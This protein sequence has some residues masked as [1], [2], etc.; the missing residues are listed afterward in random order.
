MFLLQM[1]GYPGGGK[2]T[3]SKMIAKHLN[4]IVIDRDIIKTSMINSKVPNDI[5]ADASYSVVFDLAEFYLDMNISVIIDTPCYYEESLNNG[6][7][8]AKMYGAAYKYIECKV[9]DYSIIKERIS[10]RNGL[11]SQIKNT[12]EENFNNSKDKSKKLSDG[13]YLVIDTTLDMNYNM[14]IIRRYLEV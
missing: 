11:V 6:I 7:K 13:N 5:V 12:T 14:E 3:I 2:S 4:V 1:A 8:I 9:E 10:S